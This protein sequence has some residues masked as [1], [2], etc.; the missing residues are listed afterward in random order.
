MPDHVGGRPIMPGHSKSSLTLRSLPL[1]SV[2]DGRSSRQTDNV[3]WQ[4]LRGTIQC[5]GIVKAVVPHHTMMKQWGKV[6]E[7]QPPMTCLY[8]SQNLAWYILTDFTNMTICDF[9]ASG[10]HY[11]GNHPHEHQTQSNKKLQPHCISRPLC[12]KL[13]MALLLRLSSTSFFGGFRL[14]HSNKH[15]LAYLPSP[16]MLTHTRHCTKLHSTLFLLTPLGAFAFNS[17]IKFSQHKASQH[18]I[19]VETPWM[20]LLPTAETS[21]HSTSGTGCSTR[22]LLKHLAI[23]TCHTAVPIQSCVA[24][25]ADNTEKYH[26]TCAEQCC[27][28]EIDV[29]T[30]NQVGS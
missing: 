8:K 14:L 1:E 23:P 22:K 15:T 24:P 2:D 4:N 11:L 6:T 16:G 27:L 5:R 3:S 21:S 30:T 28:C 18:S 7:Q 13:F 9:I 10:V 19:P 25:H 26:T 29:L 17:R 12:Q 20:H